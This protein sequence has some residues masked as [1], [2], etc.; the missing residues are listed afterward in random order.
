MPIAV[1]CPGCARRY[2]LDATLA[3]RKARCKGCGREFR[4]PDADVDA[5]APK[6]AARA[7]PAD[8]PDER[9]PPR[10]APARPSRPSRPS[11][12]ARRA[13]AGLPPLVKAA[14][15]LL[16]LLT[17]VPGAALA[18]WIALVRGQPALA[19][20]LLAILGVEICLGL[21]IVGHMKIVFLAHAESTRVGL[22]TW[23]VPFYALGFVAR[24]WED[25]KGPFLAHL[26]GVAGF[27]LWAVFVPPYLKGGGRPGAPGGAYVALIVAGIPDDDARG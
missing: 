15:I 18:A 17:I 12:A 26:A 22:A 20:P 21:A 11:R 9:P 6:A 13:D 7:A 25:A 5:A 3:G 23:F 19:V 10:R 2:Q 27:I 8:D 4:V 24:R 1:S 16:A 14:L